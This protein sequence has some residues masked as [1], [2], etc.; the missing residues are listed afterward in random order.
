M[1]YMWR[2]REKIKKIPVLFIPFVLKKKL[3]KKGKIFLAF[4]PGVIDKISKH[5][6]K[7][8]PYTIYPPHN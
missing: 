5:F 1:M 3:L 4:T 7:N 8:H 2:Y 6:K